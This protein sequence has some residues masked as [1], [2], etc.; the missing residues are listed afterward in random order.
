MHVVV[1]IDIILILLDTA[2]KTHKFAFINRF[3]PGYSATAGLYRHCDT[4]KLKC[5]F[6]KSLCIAIA[7]K[8]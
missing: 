7:L 6:R 4:D 8:K 3:N 2:Y 1:V 5:V